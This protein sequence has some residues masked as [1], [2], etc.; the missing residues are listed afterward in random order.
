M[1]AIWL[2]A[3]MLLSATG[4]F[5]ALALASDKPGAA[6]LGQKPAPARRWGLRLLGWPLLALALVEGTAGWGPS[7]GWVT[8]LGWLTVAGVGLVFAFP[9]W[10]R[11]RAA[12]AARDSSSRF[13]RPSRQHSRLSTP[14]PSP[15][16]FGEAL[17]R[18]PQKNPQEEK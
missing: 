10:E 9:Y 16:R 13:P 15:F 8:W 2:D 17:S 4:G 5:L 11:A 12:A 18:E 14:S 7:V 1:T 6:L 3:A